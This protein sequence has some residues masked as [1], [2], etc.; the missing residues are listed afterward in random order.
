MAPNQ[1][2]SLFAITYY[3]TIA[4]MLIPGPDGNKLECDVKFIKFSEGSQVFDRQIHTVCM[5]LLL[6][7]FLGIHNSKN[8]FH[9]QNH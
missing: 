4:E 5:L 7:L 3:S 1:Y 9:L 8:G 6:F 2:F